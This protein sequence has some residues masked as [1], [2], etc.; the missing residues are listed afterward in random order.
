VCS[1]EGG[2]RELKRVKQERGHAIGSRWESFSQQRAFICSTSCSSP[3]SGGGGRTWGV[4]GGWLGAVQVEILAAEDAAAAAAASARAK[5]AAKDAATADARALAAVAKAAT[6]A[7]AKARLKLEADEAEAKAAEAVRRARLRSERDNASRKEGRARLL[8]AKAEDAVSHLEEATSKAGAAKAGAT[9]EGSNGAALA[10]AKKPSSSSAATKGRGGSVKKPKVGAGANGTASA[11]TANTTAAGSSGGASNGTVA[12]AAAAAEAAGV[13]AGASPAT[14][15]NPWSSLF[16]VSWVNVGVS[17]RSARG[18]TQT[19]QPPH[20]ASVT[21]AS[22]SSS[23]SSSA[24]GSS[25]SPAGPMSLRLLP[26]PFA[27]A[28]LS[29]S[30]SKHKR[31]ATSL[32]ASALSDPS[33]PLFVASTPTEVR[34]HGY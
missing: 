2:G 33:A 23:A 12:A 3:C 21:S 34:L 14:P 8:Q 10:K 17:F 27:V 13:S 19:A 26:E 18:G 20:A 5:A 16:D 28:R 7:A 22:S 32:V 15:S 11:S 31:L 24:S 4:R 1:R 9:K 30:S 29:P 6:A 25:S